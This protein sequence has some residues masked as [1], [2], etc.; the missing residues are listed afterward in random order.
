[1]RG[2]T[3]AI[4]KT[5]GERLKELADAGKRPRPVDL[6][7]LERPGLVAR[8]GSRGTTFYLDYRN[9]AR[10][11]K[12][13]KLGRYGKGY[14][15]KEARADALKY[16]NQVQNDGLDPSRERAANREAAALTLGGFVESGYAD[17]ALTMLKS[18]G[19]NLTR[20]RAG[21]RAWWGNPIASINKAAVQRWRADRKRQGVSPATINRDVAAL[22]AVLAAAVDDEL[23]PEHP[24]RRKLK[25]LKVDNE[26]VRYLEPDELKRLLAALAA[27]DAK[28]IGQR[29]SANAWRAERGYPLLPALPYY[30]DHLTPMVMLALNTGMRR[31]ELF[32][33]AWRD[34]L[35][36]Q[37]KI[38]VR[39]QRDE[40]GTG[41]TKT[42]KGR[43][44]PMAAAARLAL[45]QWREQVQIVRPIKPAALVFPNKDGKRLNSIKT[46]WG[47]LVKA[48]ELED[49]R[50][51]DCRHHFCSILVQRGVPL[52]RV[53]DLAGHSTIALTERYAHLAPDDLADAVAVLDD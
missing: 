48:A 18:A 23:L 46:A 31:G 21:F 5:E 6:R 32:G 47:K 33:L 26:R 37:N 43:Y 39:G 51:H 19:G 30:G 45:S 27:R 11:R 36:A 40:S 2:I 4:L 3:A 49:F 12:W 29:E 14:G 16:Q 34:V 42:D 15:L 22:S 38:R 35:T 17:D 20:L 7:D 1:M 9:A 24:L 25:P 10:K 52:V 13:F 28:L 50:F 8:V 41:G 44:I 53:R